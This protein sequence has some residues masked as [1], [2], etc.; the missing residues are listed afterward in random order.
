MGKALNYRQGLLFRMS[1]KLNELANEVEE[2]RAED[3][4]PTC[5]MNFGPL[6]A[7]RNLIGEYDLEAGLALERLIR[8][9]GIDDSDR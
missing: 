1:K 3:D 5:M 9:M 7:V 2:L 6:I 4:G 8:T